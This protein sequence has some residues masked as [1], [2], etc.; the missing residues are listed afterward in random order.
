MWQHRTE[1]LKPLSS[2]QAKWN[3]RK[4]R[5][6]AFE[7]KKLVSS[8]TLLYYSNFKEPFEIHTDASKL[9][10]GSV[11]SPKD[12][13]IVFYSRKLNP[14]QVNSITKEHEL[15]PIME[16]LKEFRNIL[17]GQQ[18]KVYTDHKT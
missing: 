14:T 6:K 15:L 17:L 16:T 7:I 18:I 9:Q 13:T 8:D 2:K 5:Q 3:W 12:K 10:L 1:M 4:E 11:I